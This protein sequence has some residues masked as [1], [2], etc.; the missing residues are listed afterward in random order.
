M[1][2]TFF[3]YDLETS[4]LNPRS[5][6]IMQFAGQRTDSDLR[7]IGDPVNILIKLTSDIL[8]DP[9]AILLTGITPQQ[10]LKTGITEAEFLKIFHEQVSLPGTI[11]I[12]YNTIRF[13][14]EFMR[15]LNYRNFYDP[16]QWQWQDGRSRWDLLDVVRMTRALRPEGIIW[17]NDKTGKATNRLEDLTSA[18]NIPHSNAH[19]ALAD[20]KATIAVAKLIHDKQPKLFDYLLKMRQ[21]KNISELVLSK[22]PFI[23]TSGKYSGDYLK[24]TVVKLLV[25]HPQRDGA[26]VYDLRYDPT[27]F[28][29]LSVK[30]LVAA[31]RYDPDKS[32]PR[33]PIKT[34]QYNRCPAVAPMSVL[35]N[36]S[37]QR[38]GIDLS[39]V[40]ENEHRLATITDWPARILE[41]LAVMD[42]IQEHK[43]AAR[44]HDVDESLYDGFFG[45][46]DNKLA[47]KVHEA[48]GGQLRDLKPDFKDSRLNGLLP[49]Y[50]ARNFPDTL[51][52]A[53]RE[54]WDRYR[55]AK[56]TEGES[57][58]RLAQFESEISDLVKSKRL[59][60]REIE[61]IN[62][63][64]LYETSVIS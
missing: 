10:T 61:I 31:W 17:S 18:N 11:F 9:R 42:N 48:N 64:K 21:K 38:V 12:G 25:P 16:Y 53:E 45:P 62:Q 60:K 3:F 7:P 55:L 28:S 44:D 57:D 36:K 46:S 30:Q 13:D 39:K 34:L 51:S 19:D 23:Y 47:V 43:Y 5:A 32:K 1:K 50:R 58:S 2:T 4:G 40:T 41:A 27:P 8:P 20:V 6:R 22:K 14:D 24:T 26:L 56:L 35:D 29:K 54:S 59:S 15:F 49:L 52:E 63:L 37:R 33:L